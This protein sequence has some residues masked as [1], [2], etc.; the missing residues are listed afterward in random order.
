MSQNTQTTNLIIGKEEIKK[1]TLFPS[2]PEPEPGVAVVLYSNSR[3]PVTLMPGQKLS[4]GEK[5]WGNFKN[6]YKVDITEHN[7]IFNYELISQSDIY[8]F[9]AEFSVTYFVENPSAVVNKTIN[10]PEEKMRGFIKDEADYI[11]KRYDIEKKID[12]EDRVND[13][14]HS[15]LKEEMRD[16]GIT[17]KKCRVTLSLNREA[18]EHLRKLDS[19]KREAKVKEAQLVADGKIKN[20][21]AA[22]D[23]EEAKYNAEVL[24]GGMDDT[25]ALIMAKYPGKVDEVMSLYKNKVDQDRAEKRQDKE[26]ML[27]VLR[28]MLQSGKLESHQYEDILRSMTVTLQQSNDTPQL[29]K[30]NQDILISEGEMKKPEKLEFDEED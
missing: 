26:A 18:Q 30:G 20:I 7:C 5:R 15:K 12:A 11:T 9:I 19:I 14:L 10:N 27:D 3:E 22:Q 2:I 21:K 29:Q 25:L 1:L 13:V 16:M 28:S 23:A 17:V 6:A 4:S 8:K 24:K